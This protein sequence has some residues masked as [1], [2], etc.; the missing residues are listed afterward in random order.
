MIGLCSFEVGAAS[1]SS[2][3]IVTLPFDVQEL[4]RLLDENDN[5]NGFSVAKPYT[6]L[7]SK[8]RHRLW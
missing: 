5:A 3:L 6:G 1:L 8:R 2:I 7:S 4:D